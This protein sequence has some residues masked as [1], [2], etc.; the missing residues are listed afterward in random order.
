VQARDVTTREVVPV[1]PGSPA[2]HA[3]GVVAAHGSA[4]LPLVDE[5]RRSRSAAVGP[6]G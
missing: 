6:L 2:E 1:G 4:A 5:D 3:A